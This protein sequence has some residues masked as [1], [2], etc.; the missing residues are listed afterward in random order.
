MSEPNTES[1][2]SQGTRNI[3]VSPEV[4][5]RLQ[6]IVETTGC[7]SLSDAVAFLLSP[8]IVHVNVT[9]EQRQRWDAYAHENGMRTSE[10]VIARV[11]AA[12]QYGADPGAL[13]RIHDM[14]HSLTSAAGIVPRQQSTPGSH[15]QVISDK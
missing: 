1:S 6:S 5:S 8:T 12:L 2:Q 15:R 7:Q 11:E 14:V 3:R 9:R 10:F 13:R 4:H